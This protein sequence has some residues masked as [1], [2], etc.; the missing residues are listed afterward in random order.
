VGEPTLRTERL[1]LRRWRADDLEPLTR[2]CADPLVMEH[3]PA[4]LSAE[5]SVDLLQRL[6]LSFQRHGFG[7]WAV[8]VLGEGHLIGF[9]GLSPVEGSLSFAPAVEI[10]WRLAREYWGL[11]LAFEAARVA[12]RFGF[13]E[14]AQREIVAY[15]AAR[16]ARS[17]RL[18]E[19]LGM[20][21][22]AT[23]DFNH[24]QIDVG[25]PLA[26]HVLYRITAPVHGGGDVP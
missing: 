19:R 2:L 8:E 10:G 17:R 20:T 5:E 1:L 7:F 12:L 11:G 6:E 25:D 13:E 24:P 15:T 23:E 18:M 22:D 21:H 4:P 14:L 9:V 16:N 3:F 26:P